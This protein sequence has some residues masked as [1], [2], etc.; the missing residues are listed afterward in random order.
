M[1]TARM[2]QDIQPPAGAMQ[3]ALAH[4]DTTAWDDVVL[5]SIASVTEEVYDASRH[6]STFYQLNPD[7]AMRFA[8][9]YSARMGEL[10]IRIK[11]V[12]NSRP[13]WHAILEAVRDC[14]EE[15]RWQHENHS[16]LHTTRE[17]EW[18]QENGL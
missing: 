11:A 1:A 15:M 10:K 9:Q 4:L 5:G 6:A 18:K 12:V 2:I 8:G 14:Q 7:E 3:P 16:R 17:F 13:G